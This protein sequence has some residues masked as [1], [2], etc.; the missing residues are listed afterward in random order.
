MRQLLTCFALVVSALLPL[1]SQAQ[2]TPDP[3]HVYRIVS[4][5]TQLAIAINGNGEGIRA[6]QA[7]LPQTYEQ[8]ASQEW[9]FEVTSTGNFHIKNRNSSLY[10][11]LADYLF[12]SG[13]IYN[14]YYL[15]QAA[16][17]TGAW[18]YWKINPSR[19][20]SGYE[21]ASVLYSRNLLYVSDDRVNII[22][23]DT[24]SSTP[25]INTVWDIID[26]SKNTPSQVFTLQ[27]GH[28]SKYLT[29]DR[30]NS[31]IRHFS[32]TGSIAEQQ[33]TLEQDPLSQPNVFRIVNRST[34]QVIRVNGTGI[35]AV[36]ATSPIRSASQLWTIRDIT[37]SR[38][39]TIAE[40]TDGRAFQIYNDYAG[41]V[42]E[43]HNGN[44][45]EG[46]LAYMNSYRGSRWQ[47]WHVGI[48]SANRIASV[49]TDATTEEPVV[50]LYP[51][52][53]HND[54]TIKLPGATTPTMIS[55]VDQITGR[56]IN[57]KQQ[58]N[59]RV[60]VSGLTPGMYILKASDNQHTYQ[61]KFVK[62]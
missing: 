39:L 28:N 27:T 6:Y 43:I 41:K 2:F 26:V 22:S 23:S 45:D 29:L 14:Q 48:K 12:Q 16:S 7:A 50:S 21:I 30:S 3:T 58:G 37:N 60:D 34:G 42:L 19:T 20:G 25:L 35:S 17:A 33:W 31:Q 54:L 56:T 38:M 51:N 53:A 1:V 57:V 55:V 13:S 18:Q 47:Q 62:E 59:G 40:A 10:L 11:G 24:I 36:S 15:E 8:S 46:A 9:S 49:A 32:G 61:Q 52:P 44:Q 5:K 4:R